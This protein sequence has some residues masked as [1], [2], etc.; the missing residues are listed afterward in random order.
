MVGDPSGKVFAIS[1]IHVAYP[2]NRRIVE[3][4]APESP[5]D[6]LLLAGDVGETFADIE[7]AL[8]LLSERFATVIWTPGNHELWTPRPDPVQLRGEFRYRRLVEVCRELGVLTPEDPYPVWR[9]EGGP[10]TIAP[11]FLLYDYTFRPDGYPTREA[12]LARAYEVGVVCTDEFLLHPDPY[13]SRQ[14]WC[15]QRVAVT[16][17]L[18]AARDPAL[19]TVLVNHFP[20]IREPTRVLRYPEF[21]QWCG[22]ER[23][24]D[25]HV[26]FGAVTVVYGHLHIPRTIWRDGVPFEEVSLGYPRE[27]RPRSGAPGRLRQI[28][29]SPESRGNLPPG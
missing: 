3:Q 5:G 6:W 19:P 17:Q 28:L 4:L 21:A 12:A 18:L 10:V 9:G 2:E 23:T 7:W 29:P 20:L 27:W 13:P 15:A 26:R 16:E 24:D 1:D 25:W 8:R 14:A 22:T 11:L